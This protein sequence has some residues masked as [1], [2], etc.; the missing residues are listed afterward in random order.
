MI[1]KSLMKKFLFIGSGFFLIIGCL[2]Y[3]FLDAFHDPNFRTM[4]DKIASADGVDL[5]GLRDL[6]ASGGFSVSYGD[7]KKKA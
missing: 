1:K 4:Q 7:I 5:T 6:R 2:F 3:L